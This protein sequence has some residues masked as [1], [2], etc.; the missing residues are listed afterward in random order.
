MFNLLEGVYLA[1]VCGRFPGLEQ[2]IQVPLGGLFW[3]INSHRVGEASPKIS[4]PKFNIA[5]E[6]RWLEDYFP[7]Y[8]GCT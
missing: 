6:K 1:V 2:E 4:P 7:N 8:L 3:N 5:P